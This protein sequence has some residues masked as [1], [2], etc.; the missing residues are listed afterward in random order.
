M[1]W[2]QLLRLRGTNFWR[3]Y[4][5]PIVQIFTSKSLTALADIAYA[6]VV[7]VSTNPDF[8]SGGGDERR[9][10]V[11]DQLKKNDFV[12]GNKIADNLIN[13]AIEL[14]VARLKNEKK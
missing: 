9:K 13:I 11:A 2:T 3:L 1:N 14:A 12:T 6:L 5:L 8:L 10:W 4:L 7:E